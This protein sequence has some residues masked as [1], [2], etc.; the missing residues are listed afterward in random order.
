MLLLGYCLGI[1]SERRLCEEVHLNLVYRWFCRLGLLRTIPRF[2]R[3]A[4]AA[5]EK[6]TPSGMFLKPSSVRCIEEGLV[7]GEGFAVDATLIAADANKQPSV[8]GSEAMDF[9]AHRESRGR[10]FRKRQPGF[11][12]AGIHWQF[13]QFETVQGRIR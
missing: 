13:N 7:D 11:S 6:A 8:P 3:T 5:S 4:T 1:R 2:Q 12:D 10:S 9:P